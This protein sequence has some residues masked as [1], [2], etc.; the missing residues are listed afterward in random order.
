MDMYEREKTEFQI[1]KEMRTKHYLTH[2]YGKK[3]I[4]CVACNGSG[5]YDNTDRWGKQPKCGCCKG[6]GRVRED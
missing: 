3:L 6:T 5:W 4:T 1:R 2:I